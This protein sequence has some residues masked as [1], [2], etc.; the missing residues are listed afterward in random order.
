MS[1]SMK[2]I[3]SFLGGVFGGKRQTVDNT[4][5]EPGKLSQSTKIEAAKVS[6][7]AL[8]DVRA[9]ELNYREADSQM[10]EAIAA[11][12]VKFNAILYSYVGLLDE[13]GKLHA[14]DLIGDP[15]TYSLSKFLTEDGYYISGVEI[16]RF[17]QLATLL[18][19][20]LYEF[21]NNQ[22]GQEY[23][24]IRL[25]GNCFVSI[26]RISDSLRVCRKRG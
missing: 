4:P 5:V 17:Q 16:I 3:L 21:K 12:L 8:G 18:V 14:H 2:S 25:L 19:N 6:L 1:L 10:L 22:V 7:D 23:Y 24:N 26:K 13:H 20:K 9:Y 15:G 11:D